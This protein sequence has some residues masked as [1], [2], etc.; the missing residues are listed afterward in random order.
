LKLE[1]AGL[2]VI[3]IERIGL[4]EEG[5]NDTRI[6]AERGILSFRF[7]PPP[8]S[9]RDVAFIYNG[10]SST[11]VSNQTFAFQMKGGR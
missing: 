10:E 8:P 9:A 11:R 7:L 6:L 1:R 5:Q 2:V 4:E 3:V